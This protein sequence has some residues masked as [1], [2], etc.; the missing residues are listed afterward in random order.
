MCSSDLYP[1]GP[2][3]TVLKVCTTPRG[4]MGVVMGVLGEEILCRGRWSGTVLV[5]RGNIETRIEGGK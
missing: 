3:S 1:P 4:V 2:G 5:T